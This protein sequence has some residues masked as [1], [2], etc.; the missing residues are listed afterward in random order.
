MKKWIV[1]S[2]IIV[3][4]SFLRLYNI[5]NDP[6]G[7]YIDEASIGNNAYH[8]LTTGRD[9]YGFLHP[10]FFTAFGEYKMPVYIYLASLSMA[11]FGK[12]EF[13]IRF[14]SAFFGSLTLISFFF[15]L[16][17]V[18][19][20]ITKR[21][22]ENLIFSLTGTLILTTSTWHLQF[23]RAG[24]E[25]SVAI[26]F[27]TT[28]LA[29]YLRFLS[30]KSVYKLIIAHFFLLLT[31]YTYDA[32]RIIIPVCAVL[33][34]L[35]TFKLVKNKSQA[36]LTSLIFFLGLL[37]LIFFTFSKGGLIRF[38]QTSAFISYS[39]QNMFR[40]ISMDIVVYVKN[41]LSFFSITYFFH[42]GD[43]IN[44]HQ[45]SGFGVLY[46]WQL[47]FI[48]L[49]I[50][51]LVKQKT[52]TL[53]YLILLLVLAAP[54]TGALTLPSPHTLRNLLSVIPFTII[55]TIG[56]YQLFLMLSKKIIARAAIFLLFLIIGAVQFVYYIDYYYIHYPKE[57]LLDWGGSCKDVAIYLQKQRKNFRNIYVDNSLFCV[58]DYFSF[59]DPEVHAIFINPNNLSSINK[60][61]KSL[62][63][64]AKDG[65]K[66]AGSLLQTFYLPNQSHDVFALIYKL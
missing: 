26:F 46:Y 4:G 44:R 21:E 39:S 5:S 42:F 34:F 20:L 60:D 28:F 36:I 1:L 8:I 40:Q 59:Y 32:Y 57:A 25:A 64:K 24:F 38:S 52:K 43:Q 63:V 53:K 56:I 10:L 58:P 61:Q 54:T 7:L 37:P 31:F 6:P 14:P 41:L 62:L 33:V 3:F 18:L 65:K 48:I 13:A 15:L 51:F 9:Q 49:G 19:S 2:A 16:N 27:F 47:P 35:T 29:L 12:T 30:D 11:F 50:Y 23:S 22:K 66:V 55:T 45:V 17:S